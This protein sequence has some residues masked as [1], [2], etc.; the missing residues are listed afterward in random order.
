MPTV[1]LPR[2]TER[3]AILSFLLV[4]LC[5]AAL[6]AVAM[7]FWF[8]P[9]LHGARPA[10]GMSMSLREW[11][12]ELNLTDD[13]TRQLKSI[14]DDFAR[15]YDNLLSDGNTRIVQILNDDQRRKYDRMMEQ[16]RK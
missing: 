16:H 1:S 8:H 3:A 10:D 9:G 2:P 15:Y 14:L 7:S 4:F 5:G 13:Q 11:K 6:G 12:T